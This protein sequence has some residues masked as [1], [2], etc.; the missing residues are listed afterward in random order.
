[1]ALQYITTETIFIKAGLSDLI[2]NAAT[3]I[4]GDGIIDRLYTPMTFHF[5]AVGPVLLY[6]YRYRYRYRNLREGIGGI[7]RTVPRTVPLTTSVHQPFY[8]IPA[9]TF[10]PGCRVIHS[11]FT[12]L[13]KLIYT[14]LFLLIVTPSRLP[15]RSFSDPSFSRY[16]FVCQT[17][18]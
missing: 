13:V 7:P 10:Y 16:T 2:G 18:E 9:V 1:M 4:S 14:S 12:C 8:H 6:R 15:S 3:I 11:M 5:V 17:A